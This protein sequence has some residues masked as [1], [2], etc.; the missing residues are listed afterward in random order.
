MK[1]TYF[2]LIVCLVI[3]FAGCDTKTSGYEQDDDV[4]NILWAEWGPGYALKEIV[5]DFTAE[6]GIGV[7]VHLEPWSNFQYEFFK[8]M[9]KKSDKYDIVLGD[10]QWLGKGYRE[11]YYVELTS[12]IEENN[13]EDIMVPSLIEWF[14]EYPKGSGRLW[15]IPAT[16][17]AHGFAYR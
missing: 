9:E 2:L 13:I 12:W 1:L 8:E 4:I 16:G 17:A 14:S 6:S 7:N 3:I 11:G 10:S 5:K 15:S